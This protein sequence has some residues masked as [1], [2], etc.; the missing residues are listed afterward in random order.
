MKTLILV[1]VALFYTVGT[2]A[3][4][5]VVLAN[6]VVGG[7]THVWFSLSRDTT[8]YGN[9]P[10]D[11]PAG[12][13]DYTGFTLIGANGTGGFMGAATTFAQ[14]LGAPGSNVAES[15]LLP[16]TSPPTTFR[17]GLG[18]GNLALTTATF[19][20]IPLDAPIASFELAVW[21]NSSGLYPSWTQ[22]SA[23]WLQGIILAG[24]SQ[25]FVLEHIGGTFNTPPNMEPALQSFGFGVPEP[26]SVSL[27][28]LAALAC[29]FCRQTRT[30]R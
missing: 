15:G 25:E 21:D 27:F 26:S 8:I 28:L 14:L 18:A 20:N 12:T 22:A 17:T 9:A 10:N 1:S 24:K 13:T 5:T 3:Q 11:T 30:H 6:R 4:G 16:S 29:R 19:N 2:F 23:A 7:T